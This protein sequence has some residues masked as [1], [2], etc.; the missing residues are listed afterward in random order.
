MKIGAENLNVETF[1]LTRRKH[2]W[3]TDGKMDGEFKVKGLVFRPE[4][5]FRRATYRNELN[6]E[7]FELRFSL[8]CSG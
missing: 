4:G 3:I 5:K 6:S 8:D 7:F 2:E 1:H